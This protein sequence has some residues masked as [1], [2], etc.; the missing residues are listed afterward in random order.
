MREGAAIQKAREEKAVGRSARAE[1]TGHY[2]ISGVVGMNSHC[3]IS[4]QRLWPR[5]PYHD[6]C[7]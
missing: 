5:G 3:H 2:C 4:R 7:V 6:L 1:G